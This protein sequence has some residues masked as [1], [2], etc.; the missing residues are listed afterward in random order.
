MLQVVRTIALSATA[1]LVGA[2]IGSENTP[3]SD[4]FT[5]NDAAVAE[6]VLAVSVSYAGGCR[7]HEFRLLTAGG[8][9]ES[10]PVQLRIDIIHDAN[11]DLSKSSWIGS[12]ERSRSWRATTSTCTKRSSGLRR[13]TPF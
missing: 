1:V 2:C 4:P 9:M 10:D 8:F 3:G 11:G 13:R 7:V 6:D 12:A 5:L